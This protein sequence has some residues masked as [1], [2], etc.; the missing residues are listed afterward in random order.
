MHAPDFGTTG[1]IDHGRFFRLQGLELRMDG[2]QCGFGEAGADF[3]GVAQLTTVA[4]M[5]AQQQRTESTA[6]TLWI[7]E[8]DDHKFLAMLALELDPVAAAPGHV[9]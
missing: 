1:R 3:A 5:Q 2:A 6:R 9:R 8:A 4:V 7:S